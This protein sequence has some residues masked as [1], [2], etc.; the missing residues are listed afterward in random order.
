MAFSSSIFLITKMPNQADNLCYLLN[1]NNV[2]AASFPI[3]VINPLSPP[4]PAYN[5]YDFGIFVSSYSVWNAFSLYD[6]PVTA[7]YWL[8][9]GKG[10]ANAMSMYLPIETIL[11]KDG[12]GG[13]DTVREILQ[14]LSSFVKGN[15]IL[16]VRG[17]PT[18]SDLAQWLREEGTLLEEY[19][20][21]QR[22][23]D[24]D[25]TNRLL[26]FIDNFK[27][28]VL[29]FTSTEV[30]RIICSFLQNNHFYGVAFSFL[31]SHPRIRDTVLGYKL[32]PVFLSSP[33]EDNLTN[34][35]YNISLT[36]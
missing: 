12:Y 34:A 7:N 2:C 9:T 14:G 1:K 4:L 23:L 29:V 22:C 19:V 16:L 35:I 33:G 17:E 10:T 20:C 26:S 32:G 31:C 21:Y 8:A 27:E 6:I 13:S 18:R 25:W 3:F 11:F 5:H 30:A 24:S 28:I 15:K 36:M